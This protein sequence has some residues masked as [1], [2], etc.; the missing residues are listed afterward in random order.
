MRERFLLLVRPRLYSRWWRQMEFALPFQQG[1]EAVTSF[2]VTSCLVGGRKRYVVH[3]R[4]DAFPGLQPTY[5]FLRPRFFSFFLSLFAHGEPFRSFNFHCSN[6][7]LKLDRR[8][9][10]FGLKL[11]FSLRLLFRIQRRIISNKKKANTFNRWWEQVSQGPSLWT[12]C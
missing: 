7:T 10:R 9:N 5:A 6:D 12:L 3:P 4:R 11:K 2:Y 8:S 1:A